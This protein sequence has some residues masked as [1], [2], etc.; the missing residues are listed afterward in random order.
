MKLK[1]LFFST[2]REIAGRDE[3]ILKVDRDGPIHVRDVLE[4]LY[5]QMP[6]LADWDA[7]VLLAL[8]EAYVAREAEVSEGQELAIMPP[9]QG[10]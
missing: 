6:G 2:L 7:Q 3:M 1:V 8:D 10:G 5:G 9:V 4:M